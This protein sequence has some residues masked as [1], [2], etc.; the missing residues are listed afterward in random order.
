MAELG[1]LEF[2]AQGG[3]IGAGVSMWLA[4]QYP[5]SV[6]GIHLNYIPGGYRPSLC[7]DE[8]R[9]SEEEQAHLRRVAEWTATG[10]FAT[11]V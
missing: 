1:Y 4:R 11:A 3:D 8:S 6:V 7:A 2:G 10:G 9:P 5:Q